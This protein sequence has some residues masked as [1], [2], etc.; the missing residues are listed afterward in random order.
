L[1]VVRI[2]SHLAC[3][4]RLGQSACHNIDSVLNHRQPKSLAV[5][6]PACPEVGFNITKE[7]LEQ[8]PLDQRYIFSLSQLRQWLIQLTRHKVTKFLCG[9]GNFRLVREMNG[10]FDPDDVALADGKAY[11]SN[12]AHFMDH[13][14]VVGDSDEVSVLSAIFEGTRP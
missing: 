8:V 2:W 5:R 6:C 1:R 14:Q 12:M 11:F 9:D 10:K 3:I 4:R 7:F 13:L